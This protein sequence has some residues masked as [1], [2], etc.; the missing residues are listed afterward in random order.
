MMHAVRIAGD[1]KAV[2][3]ILQRGRNAGARGTTADLDAVSPRASARDTSRACL[4]TARIALRRHCVVVASVPVAAPLVN[5]LA[6]VVE[7]VIVRR[8]GGTPLRSIDP[9]LG[10]SA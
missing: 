10:V 8:T 4:R 6:E 1:A 5:V 2:I 7:T 3:G 9:A